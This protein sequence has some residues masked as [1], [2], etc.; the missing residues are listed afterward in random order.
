MP[1]DEQHDNTTSGRDDRAAQNEA[2]IRLLVEVL[3]WMSG[4]HLKGFISQYGGVWNPHPSYVSEKFNQMRDNTVHH[5]N[6]YRDAYGRLLADIMG[7]N[8]F[9][10]TGV[11]MDNLLLD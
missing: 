8:D 9:P 4:D 7:H 11:V 6:Q 3:F 10:S 5:L 1:D 2:V